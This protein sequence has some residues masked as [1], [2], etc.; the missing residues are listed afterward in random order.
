VAELEARLAGALRDGVSALRQG[1]A[2]QAVSL[3]ASVCDYPE[4]VAA[5]EL[6]DIRTRAL[7]LCAEALL[8]AGRPAEA[9]PRAETALQL[10]RQLGDLEG[11]DEIERLR[12]R[13]QR[14]AVPGEGGRQGEAS[15]LSQSLD[16]LELQARRPID[17]A[18]LLVRKA[19]AE[20]EAGH[21]E[22]AAE[23]AERALLAAPQYPRT[24][25]LAR[26]TLA[27]AQPE[28]AA[29]LLREAA[30]IGRD[31]EDFNLVGWVARS[32]ELLGLDLRALDAS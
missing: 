14:A 13:I 30:E 6:L 10:A 32:A 24:S 20:L 28:R 8:L 5:S 22:Q 15:L 23:A 4:F 18:E 3:L 17:R 7:S 12:V 31:A 2:E 16:E 27:R 19:T 11:V 9:L 21:P 1:Q 29:Q 25:V 26:L